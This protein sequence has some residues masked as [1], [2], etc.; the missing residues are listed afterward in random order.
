MA[1]ERNIEDTPRR[2]MNYEAWKKAVALRG[3]LSGIERFTYEWMEA[4]FW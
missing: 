3:F 2:R 4:N 1:K